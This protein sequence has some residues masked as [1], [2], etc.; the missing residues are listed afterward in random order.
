MKP[1]AWFWLALALVVVFAGL[2]PRTAAASSE[3]M[4]TVAKTKK[5][6]ARPAAAPARKAAKPAPVR[7]LPKGALKLS[8]WE[9]DLMRKA[10]GD[11][12]PMDL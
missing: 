7:N 8:E 11:A 3:D 1:A 10:G 12:G 4:P 9:H 5:P 6:A 2:S